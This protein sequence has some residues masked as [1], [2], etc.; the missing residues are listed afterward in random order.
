MKR[1]FGQFEFQVSQIYNDDLTVQVE[2][3]KVQRERR[4]NAQEHPLE[5][6]TK[7]N[8]DNSHKNFYLRRKVGEVIHNLCYSVGYFNNLT[9]IL[10]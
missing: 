1:I 10:K 8:S 7:W 2:E 4:L 9:Q 6:Q 5:L 3:N